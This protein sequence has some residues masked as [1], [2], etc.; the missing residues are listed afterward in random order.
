MY[1]ALVRRMNNI[2]LGKKARKEEKEITK[3][4]KMV[5]E[6]MLQIRASGGIDKIEI[7]PYKL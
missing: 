1:N 3:W 4:Y 2:M 6:T 5:Y 7:P